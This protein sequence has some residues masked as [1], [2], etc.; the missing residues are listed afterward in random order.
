M[1]KGS[2]NI[3]RITDIFDVIKKKKDLVY[4]QWNF[5]VGAKNIY[6]TTT[7]GKLIICELKTGKNKDFY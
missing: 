7:N 1:E 3:I 2:G 4:I 6:L 5:V